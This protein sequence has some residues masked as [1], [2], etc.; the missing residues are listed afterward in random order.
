MKSQRASK[1]S[2]QG[3]GSSGGK[4]MKKVHKVMKTRKTSEGS[5]RKKNAKG[6]KIMKK[7][8]MSPMKARAL[9]RKK[10]AEHQ[11]LGLKYS[12]GVQRTGGLRTLAKT[13]DPYVVSV[14]KTKRQCAT[15][16]FE[17]ILASDVDLRAI[18]CWKCGGSMSMQSRGQVA[19]HP[20]PG[21]LGPSATPVAV[22]SM[23][24]YVVFR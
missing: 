1:S 15:Q 13:E 4:V 11:A 6:R 14:R 10:S 9:A 16:I 12:D 20:L 23:C 17:Q 3:R 24:P 2:Q 18:M 7:P 8:R 22:S 19:R 5:L 21:D